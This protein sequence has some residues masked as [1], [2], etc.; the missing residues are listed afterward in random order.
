[1]TVELIVS[2]CGGIIIVL[3]TT[4][5]FFI[6]KYLSK[7]DE[8]QNTVS[9]ALPLFRQQIEDLK[10]QMKE[11]NKELSIVVSKLDQMNVLRERLAVV[12]FALK[13]SPRSQ[14]VEG[15]DT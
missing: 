3:L 6:S 11:M 10:E 5:A 8:T 4:I 13:I 1:M 9:Q 15:N 12:E 14:S 7:N 2:I